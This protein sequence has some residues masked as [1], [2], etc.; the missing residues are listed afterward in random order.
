[1]KYKIGDRVKIVDSHLISGNA[2]KNEIERIL[3]L[4]SPPRVVTIS[5]IGNKTYIMEGMRWLWPENEIEGLAEPIEPIEPIDDRFEIL[6][7]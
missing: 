6:D 3:A 4:L 2:D 1:M 5:H 7:L